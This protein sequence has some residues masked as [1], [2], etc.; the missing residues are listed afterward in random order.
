MFGAGVMVLMWTLDGPCRCDEMPESLREMNHAPPKRTAPG[1][2]IAR[3][4][5]PHGDH[6]RRTERNCDKGSLP[7]ANSRDELGSP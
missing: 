5:P 7:S 1:G 6:G 4:R 3:A 2:T